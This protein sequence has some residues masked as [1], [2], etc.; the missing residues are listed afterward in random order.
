MRDR[1]ALNPTYIITYKY[2]AGDRSNSTNN[3]QVVNVYCSR[4]LPCTLNRKIQ[5]LYQ[6]KED[7][8]CFYW[9]LMIALGRVPGGFT[10]E[11]REL[12]TS[13]TGLAEIQ[14]MRTMMVDWWRSCPEDVRHSSMW[15]WMVT[16]QKYCG[17]ETMRV[18]QEVATSAQ[19]GN[20]KYVTCIIEKLNL[21]DSDEMK[22]DVSCRLPNLLEELRRG[23]V[24]SMYTNE[25]TYDFNYKA[26]TLLK[27]WSDEVVTGGG[28]PST[29]GEE[30]SEI[31][32][33]LLRMAFA[34]LV[35]Y[36]INHRFSKLTL[37][38]NGYRFDV[39]EFDR[40]EQMNVGVKIEEYI[41][42]AAVFNTIIVALM[43]E[44]SDRMWYKEDPDKVHA[45]ID[46][47]IVQVF[48][49]VEGRPF[50][51]RIM[52][53][54]DARRLVEEKN[55]VLIARSTG[56][57][58][59]TC[60]RTCPAYLP[61]THSSTICSLGYVLRSTRNVRAEIA[62]CTRTPCTICDKSV[63]RSLQ[64]PFLYALVLA[65]RLLQPGFRY[66]CDKIVQCGDIWTWL[67]KLQKAS[68]EW[69]EIQ[70]RE[71]VASIHENFNSRF[72][73]EVNASNTFK[74]S[75]EAVLLS[76][77]PQLSMTDL[78][79]QKLVTWETAYALSNVLQKRIFV[80]RGLDNI[81]AYGSPGVISNVEW[82]NVVDALGDST[83]VCCFTPA[84][85]DNDN[86]DV[87]HVAVPL[88]IL[89]TPIV[90]KVS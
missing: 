77:T 18:T 56:H 30:E 8:N 80:V 5:R 85:S 62:K 43:L 9:T 46:Q 2:R 25:R 58:Q 66:C 74:D 24:A 41:S 29:E 51:I 75:D 90:E 35:L 7:K 53:W 26:Y 86:F 31:N 39:E 65:C 20:M 44:V 6:Q 11:S 54:K 89:R 79:L 27:E 23:I 57:V 88:W 84:T 76:E 16:F 1:N 4:H 83:G 48:G 49:S 55:A 40:M 34:K 78:N 45:C 38:K 37:F 64:L 72:V 10:H 42:A 15:R 63:V 68:V 82:E 21:L 33:V 87:T 13:P 73:D 28:R 12:Y 50:A 61:E 3:C 19:C 52:E 81:R 14:R 69:W 60:A 22:K 67:D 47:T 59:P 36:V 17:R 32:E 71:V 70:P